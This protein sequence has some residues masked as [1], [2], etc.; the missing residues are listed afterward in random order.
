MKTKNQVALEPAHYLGYSYGV[1][2]QMDQFP[3]SH[4]QVFNWFYPKLAPS[5]AI[6]FSEDS[7]ISVAPHSAHANSVPLA[8]MV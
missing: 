5:T 2:K 4:Q 6:Q 7:S 3:D 1:L 8:R